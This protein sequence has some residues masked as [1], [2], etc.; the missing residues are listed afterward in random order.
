VPLSA[1]TVAGAAVSAPPDS[2]EFAE[3]AN[4]RSNAGQ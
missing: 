2:L 3:I 1:R 4:N